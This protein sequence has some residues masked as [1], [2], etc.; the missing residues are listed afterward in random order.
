V[1][2]TFGNAIAAVTWQPPSSDGGS[3]ITSYTV[4]GGPAPVTV[5]ANVTTVMV[6]GL[7]NGTSYSFT[8]SATN[9][10]GIGPAS[11]PSNPVT[12]MGVASPNNT[13]DSPV[14]LGTINCG[15][16][17]T[18]NGSN[19]TGTHAWYTLTAN[20]TLPPCTLHV[21]Q[22]SAGGFPLADTFD[23]HQGV[24]T[25]PLVATGVTTFSTQTGGTYYIDVTGGAF[26]D[27]FTL[28]VSAN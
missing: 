11:A 13:G 24:A 10:I 18:S 16:S 27:Q 3:P 17:T 23:V 25:G 15:N 4:L 21:D 20:I 28:R 9:A 19:T 12:P 6:T 8:V 14:S 1:L 2:P 26:G 22:S 5:S 7:T